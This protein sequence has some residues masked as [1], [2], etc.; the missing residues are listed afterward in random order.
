MWLGIIHHV[1]GEHEWE[2]GVYSHGQLTREEGDKEVL[3]KDSKA[4]D[5]LRKI[6]FDPDWLRSL[7][8]YINFRFAFCYIIRNCPLQGLKLH[9]IQAPMR[10]NFP[11]W[12]PNP[13]N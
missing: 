7:E 8:H 11:R 3:A 9:L 2:D 4:A 6:V 5:E 1:C 13:E 10:L 12:R